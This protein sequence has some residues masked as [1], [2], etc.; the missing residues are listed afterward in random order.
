MT[1]SRVDELLTARFK[2]VTF[3]VRDEILTEAGR[4]IIL[5]EYPNS[6]D[7]FVEDIGRLSPRFRLKAFVHGENYQDDASTLEA[8]LNS[9]GAGTLDMPVLGSL[10][11]YALPYTKKASQKTVGEIEFNLEF[12]QGR[13]QSAPSTDRPTQETVFAKG[14]VA[15]EAVKEQLQDSWVPPTDPSSV[16]VA[17]FDLLESVSSIYDDFKT[18]VVTQTELEKEVNSIINNVS[19]I[20]RDGGLLAETLV[21]RAVDN[22]LWQIISTYLDDGS[23]SVTDAISNT[24]A[25]VTSGFDQS[26]K[27]TTAGSKLSLVLSDIKR[28]DV[29]VDSSTTLSQVETSIPVWPATTAGRVKRNTN[30]LNMINATR[31]CALITAFEQVSVIKYLTSDSIKKARSVVESNYKRLMRVDTSNKDIVQS[32][33]DVRS[34]IDDLRTT[35]LSVLD[36]KEQQAYSLTEIE[37]L[38]SI[39]SY[40]LAYNLYAEDLSNEGDLKNRTIELRGLNP[41]LPAD[42]LIGD[43]E[44]LQA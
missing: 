30:R 20:V 15:R 11:V 42:R 27:Q 41:T 22:G 1:I 3:S 23:S 14:D 12:A 28:A 17:E 19:S 6:S 37:Q 25:D 2:G 43:I 21:A 24:A 31:V 39:G 38:T 34:A 26:I 29:P 16:A 10:R 8:V 9:S 44:V 33:K 18:A 32:D 40:E 7:R 13:S 4:R 5:H 35:A 36:Q